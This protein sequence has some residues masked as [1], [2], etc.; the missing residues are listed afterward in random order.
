[1]WIY[2]F[3]DPL[4]TVVTLK[5]Q[6]RTFIISYFSLISEGQTAHS[7]SMGHVLPYVLASVAVLLQR[8]DQKDI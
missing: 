8:M 5:I 2:N 7:R 1:M 6:M 4:C 3:L